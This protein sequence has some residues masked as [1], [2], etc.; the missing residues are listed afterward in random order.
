MHGQEQEL[1]CAIQEARKLLKEGVEDDTQPYKRKYAAADL[2]LMAKKKAET[3]LSDA[4]EVATQ[5]SLAVAECIACCSL[6]RGL[7]LIET[8]LAAEGQQELERALQYPWQ[9]TADAWAIQQQAHN[10]LAALWCDRG[11]TTVSL[12]HLTSATELHAKIGRSQQDVS[13][14]LDHDGRPA[15]AGSVDSS[16]AAAL[17]YAANAEAQYAT[18][19]YYLAQVHGH[20]GNKE[21]SAAYCA[22]TLNKQ[23]QQ[24]VCRKSC[25]KL[26]LISCHL[27]NIWWGVLFGPQ[28][29][30]WDDASMLAPVGP[31]H[32]PPAGRKVRLPACCH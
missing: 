10:A 11:D 6:E 22:A 1:L 16:W 17:N 23:L 25:F 20:A 30:L 27:P 3:L 2:L 9:E 7:A 21:H 14:V 19:L 31:A 32:R 4:T 29:H 5:A 15:S 18:T 26:V 8:D 12:Q 28:H 24:G 13:R